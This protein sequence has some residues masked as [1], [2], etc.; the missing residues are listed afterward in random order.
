MFNN[1][2]VSYHFISGFF[3]YDKYKLHS[4]LLSKYHFDGI[5]SEGHKDV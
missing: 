3:T 4:D 1:G 5:L 2:V